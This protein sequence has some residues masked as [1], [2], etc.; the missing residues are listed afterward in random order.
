MVKRDNQGTGTPMPRD[1]IA[2]PRFMRMGN[3]LMNCMGLLQRAY[4][5]ELLPVG[6]MDDIDVFRSRML[7]MP[8]KGKDKK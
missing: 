2:S 5:T 4:K 8:R 7:D 6:I 3:N 1:D